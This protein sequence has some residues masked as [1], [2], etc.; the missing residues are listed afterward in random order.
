[1]ADDEDVT[2]DVT[3]KRSRRAVNIWV[4]VFGL[5]AWISSLVPWLANL[6]G[7][8]LVALVALVLLGWFLWLLWGVFSG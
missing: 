5:V 4:P 1:M 8:I 2:R 7:L 6:I 3:R